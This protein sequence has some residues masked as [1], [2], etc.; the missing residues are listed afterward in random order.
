MTQKFLSLSF[1]LLLFFG[2]KKESS[3]QD[4]ANADLK[5]EN[6]VSTIINNEDSFFYIDFK[7]YPLKDKSLPIGVFDSGIGGLTVL[8]EIVNYDEHDNE[9]YKKGK[10][11][12]LDFENE[13]FIYLG[14]QANMPYGNYSAENKLDLL[15][16][17]IIKDAQ[18][19]LSNKYYSDANDI[20]VNTDKKQVK[21]IV[22]ACNTATAY[23][24]ESIEDFLKKAN[25]NIKV[26]GVIDAGVRGVLETI[27]KDEDAIIGVMATVGTVASKGYHNTIVKFKDELGYKGNIEIFS[28]GAIGIAEAVDEDTDY[29]DRSLKNHRKEYKGPSL[30]GDFKISKTLLDIYNFD[31]DNNKML[32]NTVNSDD[33]TILQINDPENYVRYHLVTL[34]ENIRTS[35]TTNQL[36]SIILGCTHY[37]Y[38]TDEINKVLKELYNYKDNNGDF[39][40]REFMIENIK[41]IDPA[42]NTANE[43]YTHLKN[44]SLFNPNGNI[45]NSEFYISVA[46]K[47]NSNNVLDESGRFPY[48]Y[49]YGRNANE[50][51]EYVKKVPFSRENISYD[52]LTRFQKQLPYVYQ[53]MQNFNSHN[54][55]TKN[56]SDENKI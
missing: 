3:K 40:Y 20:S 51:Q 8:K 22:V 55:K 47:D 49:K 39:L 14:D 30:D 37:P 38:L 29:F 6:I 10:D 2:C 36:K 32:C 11:D 42:I 17:H 53:L 25:I 43:L 13:S 45:K 31:F 34:M 41:L 56:L 28:Q 15:N 18:F 52:I 35:K 16:E 1:V 46:N 44:E 54:P 7:N 19:L 4:K 21:A 33:C 9:T 5:N 26:I 27:E 24:K 48:D 23:G 12:V 50:I